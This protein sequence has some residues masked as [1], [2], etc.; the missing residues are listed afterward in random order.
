M[1]GH[2]PESQ[3]TVYHTRGRHQPF[4]NGARSK[5]E[6]TH[7]AGGFQLLQGACHDGQWN[8]KCS[9]VNVMI[10]KERCIG[11]TGRLGGF[12]SG[13]CGRGRIFVTSNSMPHIAMQWR[14][15]REFAA[16]AKLTHGYDSKD[17]SSKFN[18]ELSLLIIM[19]T[20]PF[21]AH[22]VP[23]SIHAGATPFP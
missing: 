13:G 8:Q 6:Q 2:S 10:W 22:P 14:A 3:T 1:L 18:D 23:T 20:P 21:D 15:L 11:G 7:R 17:E 19:G 5:V 16:A 4:L 9:A 12:E